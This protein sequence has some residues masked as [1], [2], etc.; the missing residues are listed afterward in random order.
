MTQ[1]VGKTND[2][3]LK[4]LAESGLSLAHEWQDIRER[5]VLDS[6]GVEIGHV[7][8]LFID[9]GE[10]KVRMLAIREGGFLGIGEHHVLLPVD[11]VD[12]V[13][14]NAVHVN[15]T[16]Q[17]VVTSPVYNPTLVPERDHD[18]WDPYYS[19]YGYS[20][21]WDRGY[22]YPDFGVWP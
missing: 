9:E 13:T 17:H 21:Y 6:N 19:Y 16:K 10:R 11:A 15:Q 3:A 8:A 2:A 1:S 14:E 20:P 7:S 18:F 12:K 22:R 5:K 4:E